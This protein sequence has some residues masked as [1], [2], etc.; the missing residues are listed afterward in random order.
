MRAACPEG[1]QATEAPRKYDAARAV[2]FFLDF[3]GA[4]AAVVAV[5]KLWLFSLFVFSPLKLRRTFFSLPSERV[6]CCISFSL[7]LFSLFVSA[8][9]T[10]LGLIV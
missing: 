2:L 10:S 5:L 3:G 4:A 8:S 7:L 9:S 1:Q 6:H